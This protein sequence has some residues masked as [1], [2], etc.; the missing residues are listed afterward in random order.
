MTVTNTTL[1]RGTNSDSL[2]GVDTLAGLATENALDRLRDTGHA[3]HVTDQNNLVNLTSLNTCVAEGL[4]AW[5]DST[6]KRGR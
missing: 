4:L 3:S 1:N 6:L 5:V 2:I